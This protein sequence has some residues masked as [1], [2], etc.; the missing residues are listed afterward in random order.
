[1]TVETRSVPNT[2]TVYIAEDGTEFEYEWRCA[3]HERQCKAREAEERIA[4]V[5][6]FDATPPFTDDDEEWRWYYVTSQ[7]EVQ[8]I[9]AAFF[10]SDSSAHEFQPKAFP[11]W[12]AAI[13]T[14][15]EDRSGWMVEYAEYVEG[16]SDFEAR[17]LSEMK[18]VKGVAE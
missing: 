4:G 15:R 16:Q 1:M 12:I 9:A 8:D 18:L 14:G 17:L 5:P 10:N 2:V 6:H 7:R 3:D 11:C 13:F